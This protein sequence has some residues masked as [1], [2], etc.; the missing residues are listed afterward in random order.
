MS[1][2]QL[3]NVTTKV[4]TYQRIKTMNERLLTVTQIAAQAGL[5]EQTVR[6]EIRAKHIPAVRI[7]RRWFVPE[8]R[9]IA[10]LNGEADANVDKR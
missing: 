1:N 6:A 4:D 3:A 8:Q 9:W 2:R 7:G 10:Y 5:S